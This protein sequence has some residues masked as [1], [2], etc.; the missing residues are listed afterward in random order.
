MDK[1]NYCFRVRSANRDGVWSEHEATLNIRV[2][3]VWY[4]SLAARI[5]LILLLLASLSLLTLKLLRRNEARHAAR[6]DRMKEKYEQDMRRLRV[7]A[8]LPKGKAGGPEESE[9]LFSVLSIIEENLGD[10]DFSVEKL[11]SLLCMS[12][13]NLHLKLHNITGSGALELD[14]KS[15]V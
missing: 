7:A 8:Y 14:R 3:P 13:S 4:R 11:A 9:F 12:R 15:V 1:G 6:M 2:K 10:P 5:F